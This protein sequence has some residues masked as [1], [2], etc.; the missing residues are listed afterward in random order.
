[1]RIVTPRCFAP[2]RRA[3]VGDQHR[4]PRQWHRDQKDRQRDEAVVPDAVGDGG[5]DQCGDTPEHQRQVLAYPLAVLD[6]VGGRGTGDQDGPAVVIE[7]QLGAVFHSSTVPHSS[8]A[9]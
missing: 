6:F 1:R 4:H 7:T 8:S 2:P 3:V 9:V 5:E